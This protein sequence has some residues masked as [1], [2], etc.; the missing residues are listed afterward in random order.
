M[1]IWLFIVGPHPWVVSRATFRNQS[2]SRATC[3]VQFRDGL[4]R[5]RKSVGLWRQFPGFFDHHVFHN[6]FLVFEV[7]HGVFKW[8]KKTLAVIVK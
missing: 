5:A 1:S 4:G 7:F 8:L 3:T 2:V 6:P